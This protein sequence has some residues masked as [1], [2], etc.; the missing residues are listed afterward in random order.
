M[1][2]AAPVGDR[3]YF[4]GSR[5]LN[6]AATPLGSDMTQGLVKTVN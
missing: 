4:R 3:K 1:Y 5:P 6:C 2:V